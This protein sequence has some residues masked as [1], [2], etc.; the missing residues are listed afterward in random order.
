[1]AFNYRPYIVS[2]PDVC[3]GEPVIV[4]TRVTLR[5]VLASMAEGM[6]AEEILADFPSLTRE[7]IKAVLAFAAVSAE[8]DLPLPATPVLACKSS[9][10]KICR[11]DSRLC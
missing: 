7:S 3:G 1:M 8:E 6:S 5:T 4:G 11:S 2:N 10:T 9:W